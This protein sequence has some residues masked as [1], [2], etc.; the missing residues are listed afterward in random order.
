MGKTFT[1]S[2]ENY[3]SPEVLKALLLYAVPVLFLNSGVP[4]AY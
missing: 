3:N 1:A 4:V 2:R